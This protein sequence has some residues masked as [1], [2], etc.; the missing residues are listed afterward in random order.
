MRRRHRKMI[1]FFMIFIKEL[2]DNLCCINSRTAGIIPDK[3]NY[4]IVS[5]LLSVETG[6]K[7]GEYE[8]QSPFNAL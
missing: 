1:Y 4:Q 2:F 5:Y 6:K 3:D 7:V 8:F